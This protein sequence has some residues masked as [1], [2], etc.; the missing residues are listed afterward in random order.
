MKVQ[1]P[2]YWNRRFFAGAFNFVELEVALVIL[3]AGLLSFAGL[4]RIYSLQTNYIEQISMPTDPNDDPNSYWIVSQSNRWMRQLEEPADM[5]HKPG[6]FSWEPN[7]SDSKKYKIKLNS[8][9]KD[10]DNSQ[11]VVDV[12]LKD[13]NDANE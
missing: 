8:L 10:F 2:K 6:Q 1:S 11:A 7:V 9:S 3:A 12:T 4:F 5:Y 13:V